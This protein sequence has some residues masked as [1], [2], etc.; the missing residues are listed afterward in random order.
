MTNQVVIYF[1]Y[2]GRGARAGILLAEA[3]YP[4]VKYSDTLNI[5]W[6][7]TYLFQLSF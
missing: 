2:L 5:Y 3:T 6:N 4:Q 7:L 1:L